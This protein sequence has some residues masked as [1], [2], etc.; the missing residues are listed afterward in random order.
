MFEVK[1]HNDKIEL[2]HYIAD[3]KSNYLHSGGSVYKDCCEYFPTRA[4][5]EAV[6]AKYPDAAPPVV[7]LPKHVWKNGDVF[8][9]SVSGCPMIYIRP[10]SSS[11]F[12][13]RLSGHVS[14]IHNILSYMKDAKFLFNI[15]DVVKERQAAID[16]GPNDNLFVTKAGRVAAGLVSVEEMQQFV[17]YA[18]NVRFCNSGMHVC[19][20]LANRFEK[21]LTQIEEDE[22]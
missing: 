18:K 12:V 1:P 7:E 19:D 3:G 21:L 2:Q 16:A 22:R 10:S 9:S 6:L 20:R 15:N 5:A 17:D 14:T 11:A 4:D 13:T 8:E